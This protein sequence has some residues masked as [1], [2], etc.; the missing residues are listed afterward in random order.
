VVQPQLLP[1]PFA[2]QPAIVLK[3]AH[4]SWGDGE[5]DRGC[6]LQD[7]SLKVR[8]TAT[9]NPSTDWQTL[10]QEMCQQLSCCKQHKARLCGL[11]A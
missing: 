8:C 6:T 1:P 4:F 7:I 11:C 10:L 9:L 5:G 2:G 3:H